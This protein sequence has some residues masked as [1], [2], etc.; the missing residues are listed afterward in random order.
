ML[1]NQ[2]LKTIQYSIL[3]RVASGGELLEH[4]DCRDTERSHCGI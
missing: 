1:H 3:K 4:R 2:A